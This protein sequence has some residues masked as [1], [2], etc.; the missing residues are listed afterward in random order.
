M[1]KDARNVMG[2]YE[3]SDGGAVNIAVTKTFGGLD[4]F[5][6]IIMR[7]DDKTSKPPGDVIQRVVLD[8]V[9]TK[10]SQ[11]QNRGL[12]G[13]GLF[14]Q[15]KIKNMVMTVHPREFASAS[16]SSH[17]NVEL[18]VQEYRY[19]DLLSSKPTL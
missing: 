18:K 9:S 2:R 17:M 11:G 16:G 14:T 15:E 4:P 3:S 8:L 1:F 5:E 12:H 7:Y 13:E 19:I 10:E 6:L